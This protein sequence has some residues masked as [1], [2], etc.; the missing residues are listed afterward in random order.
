M[1]S[2]TIAPI[3]IKFPFLPFPSAFRRN[4]ALA[5][6]LLALESN[7]TVTRKHNSAG[8]T[9]KR[10]LTEKPP[11]STNMKIANSNSNKYKGCASWGSGYGILPGSQGEASRRIKKI[12]TEE[13]RRVLL[14]HLSTRCCRI[15]YTPI[16]R[17]ETDEG[18][19][20]MCRRI[21][22]VPPEPPWWK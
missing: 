10:F 15:P 13:L 21:L 5:I 14:R 9:T 6:V 8:R 22:D 1:T 11:P 2:N 19:R 16:L 3:P 17:R 18:G 20:G 12:R 7:E 4:G